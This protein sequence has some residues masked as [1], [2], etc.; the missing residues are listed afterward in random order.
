MKKKS[1]KEIRLHAKNYM[2]ALET[3]KGNGDLSPNNYSKLKKEFLADMKQEG[4][5][6]KGT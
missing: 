4:I 3:A 5:K 2:R 6:I 1:K